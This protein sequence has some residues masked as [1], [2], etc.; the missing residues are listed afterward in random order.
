MDRGEQLAE[1]AGVDGKAV[2]ESPREKQRREHHGSQQPGHGQPR[3]DAEG[4]F[5][6][7]AFDCSRH[8]EERQGTANEEQRRWRRTAERFAARTAAG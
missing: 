5:A 8:G 4:R 7:E 1:P 2:C 6:H 3:R